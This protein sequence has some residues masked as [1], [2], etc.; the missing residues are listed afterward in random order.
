[1]GRIEKNEEAIKQLFGD[2]EPA[3]YSTDPVFQNILSRFQL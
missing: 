2:G 1:M 3:T